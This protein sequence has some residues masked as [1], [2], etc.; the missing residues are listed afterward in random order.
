MQNKALKDALDRLLLP[1]KPDNQAEVVEAASTYFASNATVACDSYGDLL[2]QHI[3]SWR[4]DLSVSSFLRDL[5]RECLRVT[6]TFHPDFSKSFFT[7]HRKLMEQGELEFSNASALL[8]QS[9][10]IAELLVRQHMSC[11]QVAAVLTAILGGYEYNWK[12]VQI[13]ARQ[14]KAL[15][16]IDDIEARKV[17]ETD[18]AESERKFADA[19][20][21]ECIEQI[22]SEAE[23]LGYIGPIAEDLQRFYGDGIDFVPQYAVILHYNL[24]VSEFFDHPANAAYEFSPRSQLSLEFQREFHPSYASTEN[25]YLNNS[26][27]AS[28]FDSDWAWSR[29]GGLRRQALALADLLFYLSRMSYPAR[30]ELARS[31]RAWL[32]RIESVHRVL[33]VTVSPPGIEGMERF[34]EGVSQENSRTRGILEQRAVD[35]FAVALDRARPA[36]SVS[37]GIG[38]SVSASNSARKK[39]GDVEFLYK[40]ERRVQAFEAHGGAL[41]ELYVDLHRL[42]LRRILKARLVELEQ[43]GE[44]DQWN[45]CIRFIAH[46][47]GPVADG[48]AESH[49]EGFVVSWKFETFSEV[50]RQVSQLLGKDELYE[51]FLYRV[52]EPLQSQ[53]VPNG[54]K[55]RFNQISLG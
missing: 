4:H 8:S 53:W 21:V 16:V 19:S 47:I 46:D 2:V 35:C 5:V 7:T 40:A 33:A 45:M 55:E 9:A 17:Y 27:G 26:K 18:E 29:K 34:F 14:L 49:I 52:V 38:D 12:Q 24:L 37:R 54:V 13:V 11:A 15:P 48:L 39:L 36:E 42:S 20:P 28:A 23:S 31:I 22:A 43:L 41:E 32:A 30:R 1:V 25:A 44:A 51:I 10:T 50:W 6:E 3:E